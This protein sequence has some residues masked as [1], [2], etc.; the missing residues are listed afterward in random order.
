M[1]VEKYL[2]NDCTMGFVCP[3]CGAD[4]SADS[5]DEERECQGGCG[6]RYQLVAY[7]K[8]TPPPEKKEAMNGN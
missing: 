7:L 1:E 2:W 5:Q 8:I 4:N 6:Y 3:V